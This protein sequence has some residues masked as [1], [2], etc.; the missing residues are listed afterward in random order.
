MCRD[1][2]RS[3][4]VADTFCRH[5]AIGRWKSGRGGQKSRAVAKLRIAVCSLWRAN[6]IA[7]LFSPSTLTCP[8]DFLPRSPR[9]SGS[10]LNRGRF[11]NA[12]APAVDH[13][14]ELLRFGEIA[15]DV[16]PA[17]QFLFRNFKG[18]SGGSEI[19]GFA[20][21]FRPVAVA[22]EIFQ[23]LRVFY[24]GLHDGHLGRFTR[25]TRIQSADIFHRPGC[26]ANHCL[27]KP[28]PWMARSGGG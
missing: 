23:F 24:K 27:D 5:E 26:S 14:E 2:K 25:T 10:G 19:F 13:V 6:G 20:G 1:K 21:I 22:G 17:H 4:P 28:Q 16:E 18:R 9:A 11:S 15:D 12:P 3:V 7:E 8:A